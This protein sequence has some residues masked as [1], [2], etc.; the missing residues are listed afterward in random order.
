MLNEQLIEPIR[1]SHVTHAFDFSVEI[2]SVAP[3]AKNLTDSSIRCKEPQGLV[4]ELQ[5]FRL[6]E[7]GATLE[8][9]RLSESADLF[10]HLMSPSSSE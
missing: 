3:A 8:C 6:Q 4:Q 1:D 5:D 7:F 2:P 10:V 9:L